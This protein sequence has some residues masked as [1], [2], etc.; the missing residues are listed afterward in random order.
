MRS[1]M[2]AGA[3]LLVALALAWSAPLAAQT[4]P[5][6]VVKLVVPFPAG[7]P[8]DAM[9]RLI[10]EGLTQGAGWSLV[11]ENTAGAGGSTGSA[12]VSRADPDGYTILFGN[13][14]THAANVGIYKKLPYD[15]ASDF[16]P[17]TLVANV[18]F[19]IAA[20]NVAAGKGFRFVS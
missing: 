4:F 17:V 1:R 5:S 9:A 3:A 12:R 7:G 10:A 14:G 20:R 2:P 6:H 16:E 11:I 19:V 13:I 18:P 15:P 8:S